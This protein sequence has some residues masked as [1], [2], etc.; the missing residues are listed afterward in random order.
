MKFLSILI[1]ALEW[2]DQA[3]CITLMSVISKLF[4]F[5]CNK[6]AMFLLYFSS[7]AIG[8]LGRPLGAYIFGYYSDKHNRLMATYYSLMLMVSAGVAITLIPTYET[9]GVI[10][11]ILFVAFRFLQGIALGGNYGV[12]VAVV[13]QADKRNRYYVSSYTCFGV[14]LGFMLGSASVSLL[15]KYCSQEALAYMWRLPFLLCAICAV[16]VLVALK[17]IAQSHQLVEVKK[18]ISGTI[19]IRLFIKLLSLLFAH[20][21]PFYVVFVFAPNYS[22]TLLGYDAA[23]VW[24]NHTIGMSAMLL[25]TP[26]FGICADK[27]GALRCLKFSNM[28]FVIFCAL[29]YFQ[30]LPLG[31]TFYIISGVTIAVC[32][33]CLYGYIPLMVPQNIRARVSNV[34]VSVVGVVASALVSFGA[35]LDT[36]NHLF[37]VLLVVSMFALGVLSICN[38]GQ[39]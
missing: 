7:L 26:I 27:L 14:M 12:T 32:Y 31:L 6:V 17:K 18:S 13:E 28:F 35:F 4:F 24:R 38:E 37:V 22:I 25:F 34:L 39:Q 15:H 33:G 1:T 16:P 9:V 21:I 5:D 3:I 29:S 2:Y 23:T 20:T 36:C 8:Y 30:Q 10:S 19:N 11:C